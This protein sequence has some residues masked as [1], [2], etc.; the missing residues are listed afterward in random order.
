MSDAERHQLWVVWGGVF[1][2]SR[3]AELEP[4]AEEFY[5]PFHHED[6][7]VRVWREG[8]MRKVDV[9]S[10]RLYIMLAR[11]VLTHPHAAA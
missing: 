11:P 1:T 6:E 2:D 8:T 9:A 10:H 4:G 5:G 3:F 7:A